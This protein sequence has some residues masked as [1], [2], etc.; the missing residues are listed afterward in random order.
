MPR[1]TPAGSGSAQPAAFAVASST[2]YSFVAAGR[3]PRRYSYGSLPAALASSSTKHSRMNGFCE[4]PTVRQKPTGT[5]GLRCAYSMR[6]LGI[7]YGWSA[8]DTTACGSTPSLSGSLSRV[9][10]IDGAEMRAYHATGLTDASSPAL[11]RTTLG[12]DKS[13]AA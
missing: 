3:K 11:M 10:M 7:A 1:C 4:W 13:H 5:C 12:G 8:N 6:T 2:P 9:E